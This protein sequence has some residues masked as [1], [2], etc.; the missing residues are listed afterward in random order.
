MGEKS[1]A[2]TPA[3]RFETVVD[4][5]AH[6]P[7]VTPPEGPSASGRKFGSNGLKF[8]GKIF[9]M[10]SRDRLV[11]KLPKRRVDALVAS[12]EGERMVSG[13]GREMKEWLVVAV[14]SQLDWTTLAR[15]AHTFAGTHVT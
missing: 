14:D 7:D 9:A 5:F 1:V 4:F 11:V 3:A 13:G 6:D 12:D 10:L 8:R 15:E 2:T